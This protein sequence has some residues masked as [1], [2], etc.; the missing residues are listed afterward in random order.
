MSLSGLYDR[1]A[2]TLRSTMHTAYTIYSKVDRSTSWT[3]LQM[4]PYRLIKPKN[5]YSND[6]RSQDRTLGYNLSF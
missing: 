6:R 4:Q 5:H 1:T 2:L 3:T